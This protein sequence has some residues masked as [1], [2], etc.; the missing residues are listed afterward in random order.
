[1]KNIFLNRTL[2]I[3][4]LNYFFSFIIFPIV[5]TPLHSEY[6]KSKTFEKDFDL[7]LSK[8]SVPYDK[9]DLPINQLDNF[10]GLKI[11]FE[12]DDKINYKDLSITVD[13]KN[14]RIL[15]ERKLNEMTTK[16]KID[17]NLFYSEKI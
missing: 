14:I 15:Y 5:G 10:F 17:S 13:S 7:E 3:I 8:N 1:M 4:Y 11:D 2:K 12:S 6:N 9:Y 16:N